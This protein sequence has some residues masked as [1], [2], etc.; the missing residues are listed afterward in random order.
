M[1]P[2][3]VTLPP[4][5]L[6]AEVY[7]TSPAVVVGTYQAAA[8]PPGPQACAGVG[9]QVTVLATLAQPLARRAVLDVG[10]G[11]PLIVGPGP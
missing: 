3:V 6:V 10:S 7:Q 2:D 9:L 11:Q 8:R 1:R 4:P 5:R